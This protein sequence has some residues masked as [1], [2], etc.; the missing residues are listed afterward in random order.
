[1]N[2]ANIFG[3]HLGC[4]VRSNDE[5]LILNK[6]AVQGVC[7]LIG[8]NSTM[9]LSHIQNCK[10]LLK[11][12]NN[13]T[14]SDKKELSDL[15]GTAV[16]TIWLTYTGGVEFSDNSLQPYMALPS[17]GIALLAS[18]GYDIGIIPDEYKE[19]IV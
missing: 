11:H 12:L 17:I 16:E 10:L 14:D 19:L 15:I 4:R 9:C 2:I 13:I 8:I 1:M 3:M 18:L 6:V 5:I 7:E